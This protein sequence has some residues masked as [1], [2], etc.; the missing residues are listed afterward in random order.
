MS[1]PFLIDWAGLSSWLL[2]DEE[3]FWEKWVKALGTFM[4][5]P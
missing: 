2:V 5:G 4:T 3:F 1:G